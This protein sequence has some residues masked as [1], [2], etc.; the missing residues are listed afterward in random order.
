MAT[1]VLHPEFRDELEFT[2]Y[3]FTD[4]S[5]LVSRDTG[6]DIGGDTFLDAS[7]HPIGGQ[8]RQYISSIVVTT[9]LVTITFS[10]RV[11]RNICSAQFNP[12]DP[13][14]ILAFTDAL[15]RPAG[16]MISEPLRLARFSAWE[17]GTHTF[18]RG[19]AELVPSCVIPTP[20]AGL[21]GIL[22]E[23]G[24]L[25]TGDVWLMGENGVAV[26]DDGDG[27]IRIDLVGDPLFLRKLCLPLE[28]FE[29]P[30]FV[31]TINGCPPDENGEFHLTIGDHLASETIIRLNPTDDGLQIEAVGARTVG[32]D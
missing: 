25:F 1:Q 14:E 15:G 17:T 32:G 11:N 29:T 8:H 2:K 6:H 31:Q 12:L 5:S 7:L 18:D 23:S 19:D 9:R 10:D 26:R 4:G 16:I 3:P 21:R 20:E 22:L 13:P 30:V 24:E 27:R 28:L